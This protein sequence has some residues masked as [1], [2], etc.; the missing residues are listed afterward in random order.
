MGCICDPFGCVVG[1]QLRG[2]GGHCSLEEFPQGVACVPLRS[3]SQVLPVGSQSASSLGDS[4]ELSTVI[5]LPGA[6]AGVLSL[7]C[8][9]SKGVCGKSYSVW[10]VFF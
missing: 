10:C 8:R 6:R 3:F 1:P 2:G 7:R 9:K 4:S 5:P